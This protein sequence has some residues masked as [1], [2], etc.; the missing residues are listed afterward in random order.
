M[1]ARK[2]LERPLIP[3]NINLHLGIV[4]IVVSLC[5]TGNTIFLVNLGAKLLISGS[6]QSLGAASTAKLATLLNS[7]NA[8]RPPIGKLRRFFR[9]M[10]LV[11][12]LASK[13]A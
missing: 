9:E 12:G 10:E 13:G 7:P 2:K 6:Q 11:L 5:F 4:A 3:P 1:K 8:P